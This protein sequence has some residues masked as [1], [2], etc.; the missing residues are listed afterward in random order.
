MKNIYSLFIVL[1]I[2]NT[3]YAQCPTLT[4]TGHD[5]CKFG[6][7]SVELRAS[8]S[9]TGL[10]SWYD[11]SV[12]G[13][14]LGSGEFFTT[15]SI[16]STTSFFVASSAINRGIDF[17]GAN[18]YIAI[19]NF[20]YS[21]TGHTAVTVEAWVKTT[22][23]TD[24][25]ICSFDRSEFW[26]L[27]I[28]G[29]GAGTGQ[30]SWCIRTNAGQLDMGSTSRVDDGQWHHVAA[31]FDNGVSSIYID[32]ILDAQQT[33]GTTFGRAVTRFGFIS[34][35]S[36]ATSFNNTRT[37]FWPF[38]GRLDDI[39]I[40]NVAKSQ[41]DIQTSMNTCLDGTEPGLDLLYDFEGNTTTVN[42]LVS[43]GDGTMF[44]MNVATDRVVVDR[45]Y[46]CLSCEGPRAEAIANINNSA[47]LDLGSGSILSC[48][49]GS[50][51]V[52]AGPGF[53]NYA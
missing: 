53:S 52:D 42:D 17:D 12:G 40:W 11:A 24:Q 13:N 46:S 31:V 38:N 43:N 14:F 20:T 41:L 15:P 3:M 26:R 45:N 2:S 47:T 18:D 25:M 27:S 1:L 48:S 4:P 23:G 28:N 7:G 39:R 35:G 6:A 36:E 50:Q 5:T 16:A 8:L 9:S 10:Y 21:G 30:V 22:D 29:N 19:D 33:R 34:A 32:G 37:P 44:N 49:A 51:I